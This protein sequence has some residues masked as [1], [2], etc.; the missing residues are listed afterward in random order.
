MRVIWSLET[1]L[2]SKQVNKIIPLMAAV[3]MAR[4]SSFLL[5]Y[6]IIF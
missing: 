4:F 2:L 6:S 1:R 3:E 5:Y